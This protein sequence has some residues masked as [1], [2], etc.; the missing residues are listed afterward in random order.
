M[1]AVPRDKI[2]IFLFALSSLEDK[3]AYSV[4]GIM[5]DVAATANKDDI[6]DAPVGLNSLS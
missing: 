2:R 6:V 5:S 4:A 3:E 1:I